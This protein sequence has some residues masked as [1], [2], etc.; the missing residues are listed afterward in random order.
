MIYPD[1]V[2]APTAML[3]VAPRQ[4]LYARIVCVHE[5]LVC[6]RREK[7]RQVDKA[8]RLALNWSSHC[9]SV[10]RESLV[11]Q[12]RTNKPTR[13]WGPQRSDAYARA[14]A[15]QPPL[16]PRWAARRASVPRT[17]LSLIVP[18]C[19]ALGSPSA[20]P[21]E[22]EQDGAE[23][24]REAPGAREA[25]RSRHQARGPQLQ[26]SHDGQRCA[27]PLH[28]P[29]G[30][31]F[32]THQAGGSPCLIAHALL[33]QAPSSASAKRRRNQSRSSTPPIQAT[34]SACRHRSSSRAQAVPRCPLLPAT[35]ARTSP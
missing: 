12:V 31:V 32:P 20:P 19:C 34:R 5:W 29:C 18:W 8:E 22:L 13:W 35:V 14:R 30:Q 28:P 23:A 10:C 6:D 3:F 1:I 17:R 26:I 4:K 24:A 33:A 9:S 15:A 11:A 2:I 7:S 27:P 16:S 21:P 25:R